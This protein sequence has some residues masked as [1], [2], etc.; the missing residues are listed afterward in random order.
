MKRSLA[1]AA[2]VGVVLALTGCGLTQWSPIEE[3][4]KFK[5]ECNA[6]GGSVWYDNLGAMRCTFEE[7]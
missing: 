5:K 3:Q 4:A 1:W 7:D 2:A 6:A